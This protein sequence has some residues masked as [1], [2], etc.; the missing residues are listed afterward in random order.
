MN[1]MFLGRLMLAGALGLSVAF[2][3]FGGRIAAIHAQDTQ[4]LPSNQ[5]LFPG[6]VGFVECD[7]TGE[8]S[9]VWN[10]KDQAGQQWLCSS[11]PKGD[12]VCTPVGG[13]SG[14]GPGGS[15][16]GAGGSGG[17]VKPGIKGIGNK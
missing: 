9:N 6:S 2:G 11:G 16:G 12:A 13:G 1:T 8:N 10:C 5:S 15:G 7:Q 4:T 17:H 14:S 3:G